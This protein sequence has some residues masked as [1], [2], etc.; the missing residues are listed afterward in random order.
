M[1]WTMLANMGSRNWFRASFAVFLW[2]YAAATFASITQTFLGWSDLTPILV[3]AAVVG[4][5]A[6]EQRRLTVPRGR[7]TSRAT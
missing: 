5:L 7:S 1:V 3:V 6:L 2:G 4:A